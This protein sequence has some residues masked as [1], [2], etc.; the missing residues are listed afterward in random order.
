MR[1][2]THASTVHEPA[3]PQGCSH[4]EALSTIRSEAVLESVHGLRLRQGTGYVS[5]GIHVLKYCKT[6]FTLVSSCNSAYL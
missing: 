4:G 3:R 5:T 2:D 1:C 6:R